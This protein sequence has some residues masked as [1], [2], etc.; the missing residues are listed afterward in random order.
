MFKVGA[1]LLAIPASL[2]AVV[3]GTGIVVVDVAEPGHHIV[4]PVPLLL[5]E[6]VTKAVPEDKMKID[7]GKAKEQLSHMGPLIQALD[8]CPDAVLV[9]V[10]DKDEHVQISKAGRLLQVRVHGHDEEVSVDVPVS[11]LKEFLGH[12]GKLEASQIVSALR[13]A[14]MTRLVNVQQGERH[15]TVSVF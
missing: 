2:L 12:D 6:A 11:F 10:Q 4:L 15:V 8:D 3:A 9:E 14:R 13:K 7:L 1:I 5:A